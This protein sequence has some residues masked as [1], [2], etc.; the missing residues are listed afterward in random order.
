METDILLCGNGIL[1]A[2]LVARARFLI[3]SV[4]ALITRNHFPFCSISHS[5]S[6]C[7]LCSCTI[8]LF[9]TLSRGKVCLVYWLMA[10]CCSLH[11]WSS[12][13]VVLL[14]V[15]SASTALPAGHLLHIGVDWLVVEGGGL[16]RVCWCAPSVSALGA[17]GL[18]CCR[19]LYVRSVRPYASHWWWSE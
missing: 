6:N 14:S 12:A 8:G 9:S 13:P 7:T 19:C 2:V 11:V 3:C 5:H 4:S 15:S 16:S 18:L 17:S 1:N 10:V